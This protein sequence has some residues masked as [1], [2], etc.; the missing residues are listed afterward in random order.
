MHQHT[1]DTNDDL[2]IEIFFF[3]MMVVAVAGG[4]FQKSKQ[5]NFQID[6]LFSFVDFFIVSAA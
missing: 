4:T 5:I 6:F 2:R 1:I 3:V